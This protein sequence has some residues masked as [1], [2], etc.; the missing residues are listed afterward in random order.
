MFWL[1][2]CCFIFWLG[3]CFMFWLGTCCFM[4]WLGTCC[5]QQLRFCQKLCLWLLFSS[6]HTEPSIAA[7][8]AL[9]LFLTEFAKLRKVTIRFVCLSV[10]SVGRSVGRSV[11]SV[12]PV[13][14]SVRSVGRSGRSVGPHGTRLPPVGFSQILIF[15]YFSKICRKSSSF[16]KTWQN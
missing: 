7:T 16:I 15:E 11:R 1:G 10:R 12:G 2:T 13:G 8:T 5:F 9:V 3:T 14:R 4:F 6:K